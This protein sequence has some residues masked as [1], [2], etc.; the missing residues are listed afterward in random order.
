MAYRGDTAKMEADL[1]AIYQQY[2][3]AYGKEQGDAIY[4]EELIAHV[5]GD[6]LSDTD[7]I[8]RI[9]ADKP[10]VARR[11]LDTIRNFINRIKG[12]NDPFVDQL[13]KVEKLMTKALEEA[14]IH[15]GRQLKYMATERP[16]S[17][18]EYAQFSRMIGEIAAGKE[19]QFE[20]A[21]NGDY[22]LAI[23]NK[24]VYTDGDIENPTISRVDKINLDDETDIDIARSILYESNGGQ[25]SYEQARRILESLYGQEVLLRTDYGTDNGVEQRAGGRAG[26]Q[27]TGTNRTNQKYSLPSPKL[28]NYQ[29]N[30]WRNGSEQQDAE[31]QTRKRERQFAGQT[32]PNSNAPDEA[33]QA[34]LNDPQQLYYDPTTNREQVNAAYTR[35]Q[36]EGFDAAVDRVLNLEKMNASDNADVQYSKKK[37]VTFADDKNYLAFSLYVYFVAIIQ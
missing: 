32:M 6:L 14:G 1:N 4:T 10:S 31:P 17:K 35:I 25:Y 24:L 11:M 8:S 30:N 13:R 15:D 26:N 27:S 2:K 9:V 3:D 12:V 20:R 22:I 18:A 19:A 34:L 23:G 33:V 29:I 7:A 36:D 5:A 37:Q 16:L 21:L 28:L